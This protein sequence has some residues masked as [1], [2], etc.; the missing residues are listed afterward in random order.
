MSRNPAVQCSLYT[1]LIP[2]T[3]DF[4][5]VALVIYFYCLYYKCKHNKTVYYWKKEGISNSEKK[6]KSFTF[7][8]MRVVIH[9]VI[10]YNKLASIK[11]HPWIPPNWTAMDL[12]VIYWS[13]TSSDL[14]CDFLGGPK[15][16]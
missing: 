5:Q 4:W 13:L 10:P 15:I 1:A 8:G 6:A 12:L 3:A 7:V 11:D 2:D 14:S 9:Y 16:K